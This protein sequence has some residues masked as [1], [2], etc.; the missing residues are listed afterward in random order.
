MTTMINVPETAAKG[1]IVEVKVL[2]SH[3][4]ETGFRIGMDGARVPRDILHALVATYNGVEVYRVD[5]RPSVS[6]NPFFAFHLRAEESG[7]VVIAWT[8]ETGQTFAE[9]R[10]ITVT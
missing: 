4:M 6:A 7:E 5:I 3:P 9:T 1:E 8:N 10:P 2:I